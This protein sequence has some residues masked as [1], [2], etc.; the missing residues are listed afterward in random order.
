[1]SLFKLVRGNLA[2][3]V[4]EVRNGRSQE[5]K[6]TPTAAGVNG[7]VQEEEEKEVEEVEEEE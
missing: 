3:K 6:E 1:M 7:W 4:V 5:R 2:V